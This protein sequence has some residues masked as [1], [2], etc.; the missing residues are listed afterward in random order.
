MGRP[1]RSRWRA[2]AKLIAAL[3]ARQRLQQLDHV[4]GQW[5]PEFIMAACRTSE[6]TLAKW[7][8]I[9]FDAK[10]LTGVLS[11]GNAPRVAS[12]QL[13]W[14][15]QAW[16][17]GEGKTGGEIATPIGIR[18]PLLVLDVSRNQCSA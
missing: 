16:S 13:R 10:V 5:H 12:D 18:C 11:S 8:E 3:L 17:T 1:A 6:I 15:S 4:A 2:V 9:D 7:S 14:A